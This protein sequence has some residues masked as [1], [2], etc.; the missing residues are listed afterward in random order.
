MRLTD[1]TKELCLSVH[2]C[3]CERET[4]KNGLEYLGEGDRW[5]ESA[6][7]KVIGL[8]VFFKV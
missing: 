3:V 8:K 5:E 2:A 7:V 6:F 1:Q 4:V